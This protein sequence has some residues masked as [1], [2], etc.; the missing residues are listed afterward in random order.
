MHF[1][2]IHFVIDPRHAGICQIPLL[3]L[4]LCLDVCASVEVIWHST[5]ILCVITC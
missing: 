1:I 5:C 4:F 3:S 2:K